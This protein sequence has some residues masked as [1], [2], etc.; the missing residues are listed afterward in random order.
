MVLNAI[1]VT[2]FVNNFN[3]GRYLAPDKPHALLWKHLIIRIKIQPPAN[4]RVAVV[5]IVGRGAFFIWVRGVG[6]WFHG[7]PWHGGWF[8]WVWAAA[9]VTRCHEPSYRCVTLLPLWPLAP[10]G[11]HSVAFLVW[12]TVRVLDSG[13]GWLR[14]A[15]L[16]LFAVHALVAFG[17]LVHALWLPGGWYLRCALCGGIERL[18]LFLLVFRL[19]WWPA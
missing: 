13:S 6:F 2:E 16:L 9:L 17:G 4:L 3:I 12:W 14:W 1:Y 15:E 7:G 18:I 5:V 8:W 19:A 10:C 11:G